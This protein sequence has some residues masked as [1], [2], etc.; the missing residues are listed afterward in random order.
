[1][2]IEEANVVDFIGTENVTGKVVLTVSDHLD[3]SDIGMHLSKLQ[4][5]MNAYIRFVEG[6]ELLQRYPDA[7]QR[8][9]VLSVICKYKFPPEGQVFL[10]KVRPT[11]EAV[12]LELRVSHL[13]TT[14][15]ADG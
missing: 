14:P 9:I 1:M 4:E 8:Q 7:K 2:S 13:S 15:V 6:G 5:K 11:L 12:G 10:D 3:W